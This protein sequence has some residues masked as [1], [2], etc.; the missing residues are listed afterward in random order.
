VTI[1]GYQDL[2]I[3]TFFYFQS[4]STKIF[5]LPI[6]LHKDL[7]TSNLPP[8]RSF[9][10]QSSSTKIHLCSSLS[11]LSHS[12]KT[13]SSEVPPWGL[14]RQSPDFEW[15]TDWLKRSTVHFCRKGSVPQAWN[16]TP[17]KE[18]L[19]SLK[20]ALLVDSNSGFSDRKEL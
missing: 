1:I 12:L 6:F 11:F 14:A 8:Q 16:R 18:K 4:S 7:F 19:Y 17:V 9:Y 2:I 20:N 13:I 3:K 5:L 10:F 15:T